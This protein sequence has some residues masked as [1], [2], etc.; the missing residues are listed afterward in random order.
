MNNMYDYF[1]T[2]NENIVCELTKDEFSLLNHLID[3]GT[4]QPLLNDIYNRYYGNGHNFDTF[5]YCVIF[6]E[7]E[8]KYDD[9]YDSYDEYNNEVKYKCIN[10]NCPLNCEYTYRRD[11]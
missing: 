1:E 9:T 5:G 11:K 6:G 2:E 7:V 8:V 10:D 3:K 4:I